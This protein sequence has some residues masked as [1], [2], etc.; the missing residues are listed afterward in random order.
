MKSSDFGVCIV[1]KAKAN[2]A[3]GRTLHR[4]PDR[5]SFVLRCLAGEEDVMNMQSKL[6]ECFKKIMR[7]TVDPLGTVM[8]GEMEYIRKNCMA[9]VDGGP[10]PPAADSATHPE[11]FKLLWGTDQCWPDGSRSNIKADFIARGL[12]LEQIKQWHRYYHKSQ[13]MII[14]DTEL[15]ADPVKVMTKA[16]DFVGLPPIK[17]D[18]KD[19]AKDKIAAAILEQWPSFEDDT[20][21]HFESKYP[22]LNPELRAE[23][24]EFYRPHNARLQSYLG[25]DFGWA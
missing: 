14:L 25:R 19:V 4:H 11:D 8:R 17:L 23:L 16:F 7:E 9:R 24:T 21:W 20:G 3:L 10:L 18:K 6:T 12:Y 13:I 22:P 2:Q 15:K 5:E 1:E